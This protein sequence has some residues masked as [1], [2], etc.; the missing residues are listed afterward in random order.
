[1]PLPD[2][3]VRLAGK[4]RGPRAFRRD[5]A[6]ASPGLEAGDLAAL[7]PA[8]GDEV[9]GWGVFHPD[10][11]IT[12]RELRRGPEPPDEQWVRDQAEAAARRRVD[13]PEVDEALCR[14]MHA[15]GDDFPAMVVDRYGELL[16]VELFSTA[17][18][19][20]AQ[21][22]LPV[23]HECLGTAHHQVRLD[24]AVARAEHE[25]AFCERSEGCPEVL[26]VTE[27]GLRYEIDLRRGHKTGFFLDQRENRARLRR[28]VEGLDGAE[29]LDVCCYT[30]GFALSAAA[31]GARS[32][33]AIDLDE[34][35]L[36]TAKRNANLN[37]E[38][39]V[40]FTQ[41]DAFSYLRTLAAN[42]R[43]FD[44]VVL[45]PPKFI[46]NRREV[47]T[48]TAKY[49]DLN[50]LAIPLVREGGLLLS[51]SCSGLLSAVDFQERVRQAGR[52]AGR[53]LRLERLTGA[54]PDHPVRLDFPE[55]AYL[56]AMWL[57]VG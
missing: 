56:K 44:V 6:D 40:K 50:K 8:A 52:R 57:R 5:V 28:R 3:W 12:W 7:L 48:G 39:R 49:H 36:H 23:L 16:S 26:Q 19:P 31:G 27:N 55:G 47:E 38:R 37:Q 54:G 22:A 13:S 33:T 10:S 14:I 51:C 2:R 53:T 45:D 9:L 21:I 4:P 18:V 46:S 1:M 25:Q 11:L 43:R 35:A 32:V 20:L 15:E 17:A 42:E 24:P 41:A 29:V 30:G 34:E